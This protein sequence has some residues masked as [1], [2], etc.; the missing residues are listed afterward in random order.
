MFNN[1]EFFF[2]DVF[3][4]A[5][6]FC[7]MNAFFNRFFVQNSFIAERWRSFLI[8]DQKFLDER[9]FEIE[10]MLNVENQNTTSEIFS[11]NYSSFDLIFE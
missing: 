4:L 11:I 7:E 3:I 5:N 1:F 8:N 2:D 9:C 6:C 10:E